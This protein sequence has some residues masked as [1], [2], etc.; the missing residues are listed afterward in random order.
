M[1]SRARQRPA[2]RWRSSATGARHRSHGLA[3]AIITQPSRTPFGQP[4]RDRAGTEKSGSRTGSSENSAS[5]RTDLLFIFDQFEEYF[6]YHSADH[7]FIDQF[8]AS[9]D[10]QDLRANFLISIRDDRLAELDRLRTWIRGDMLYNRLKVEH[11]DVAAARL[12]IIEPI[13]EFNRHD[14]EPV[15]VEPALVEAVIG[16]VKRGQVA[17]GEGPVATTD[18]ARIETPYLQLV[19][20]RLWEVE[21]EA[22]S[23]VLRLGTLHDLGGADRIVREH[24]D[25]ALTALSP[26]QQSTAADLFRYLVTPAG[27][28]IALGVGDL[29]DF[30]G[31]DPQRVG[32]V[33]RQLSEGGVRVLRT[34]PPPPGGTEARFEIFHDVLAPGHHRVAEPLRRAAQLGRGP[35]GARGTGSGI[36]ASRCRRRDR[37]PIAVMMAA[38]AIVLVIRSEAARGR[39]GAGGR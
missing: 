13:E 39:G 9:A 21:T 30:T 26:D 36:T 33:L 4:T 25:T 11:L 23:S 20:S 18:E 14:V 7:P 37:W 24:L 28:K 3:A 31:H 22:G 16:Q 38:T 10:R 6:V 1:T 19:M 12:A 35:T 15:S 32:T 29:A 17:I 2:W 8:S 34:V 27:S 5:A